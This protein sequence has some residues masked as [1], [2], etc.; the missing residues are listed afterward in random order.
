MNTV[1]RFR[2]LLALP[3]ALV[4]QPVATPPVTVDAALLSAKPVPRVQ[5]IPLPDY[6]ASFQLEGRE[7]TRFHFDP[8]RKRPFWC[9]M[10]TSLAPSLIRIGHPHDA[11]SHRHHYGVWITHSSVSGVNFWDDEA[12]NGKDKVRGSIRHQRVL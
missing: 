1:S 7:L 10:Q 9:P 8:D 3:I 5:V 12:D 6:E 2:I 4:A 11:N